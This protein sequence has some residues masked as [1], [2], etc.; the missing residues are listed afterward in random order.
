MLLIAAMLATAPLNA[1]LIEKPAVEQRVLKAWE[2]DHALFVDFA[3]KNI[4]TTGAVRASVGPGVHF[5]FAY[6]WNWL[7]NFSGA[8]FIEIYPTLTKEEAEK[9]WKL[10]L[11]QLASLGWAPNGQRGFSPVSIAVN[12][13][14]IETHFLPQIDAWR[15]DF[16]PVQLH[17]GENSIVIRLLV[18]A[19]TNYWIQKVWFDPISE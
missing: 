12:G 15:E 19:T 16:F 3:Y 1:E 8:S 17:E 7:M 18:D 10:G 9:K 4:P 2:G 13:E 5:N 14:M 6:P 11:S